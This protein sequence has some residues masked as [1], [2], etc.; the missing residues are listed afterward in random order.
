M[1]ELLLGW[2]VSKVLSE[3]NEIWSH[4]LNEREELGNETIGIKALRHQHVGLT[5]DTGKFGTRSKQGKPLGGFAREG[6]F[7]HNW[8]S[9]TAFLLM[10]ISVIC[11][12]LT[13]KCN[14]LPPIIDLLWVS[15]DLAFG[16]SLVG[17]FCLGISWDLLFS[18]ARAEQSPCK[19]AQ[20]H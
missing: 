2:V 13:P 19:M 7:I 6:N 1:G 9:Q 3:K 18:L 17:L 10:C 11:C 16:S 14:D 12:C 5:Q 15:V 4:C 20:S 8:G